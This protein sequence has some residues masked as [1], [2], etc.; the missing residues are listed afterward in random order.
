MYLL[1]SIETSNIKFVGQH[2]V[3]NLKA[4][5]H[6]HEFSGSENE[7]VYTGEREDFTTY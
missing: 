4:K 5:F 2:F 7:N 6:R 1:Y 3:Y